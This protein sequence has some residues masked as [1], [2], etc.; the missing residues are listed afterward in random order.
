M[1]LRLLGRAASPSEK[2]ARGNIV[3]QVRDESELEK[4]I[5]VRLN[6]RA[7]SPPADQAASRSGRS[8]ALLHSSSNGSSEL[9]SANVMGTNRELSTGADSVDARE[10]ASILSI[11]ISASIV[12]LLSLGLTLLAT[13]RRL[14]PM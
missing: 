14:R 11:K 1:S 8:R 12:L 9:K 2:N 4:M 7:A 10:M 6:G 13:G 5:S 3:P